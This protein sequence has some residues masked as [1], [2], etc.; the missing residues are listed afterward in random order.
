MGRDNL[1]AMD[2]DPVA[3]AV[4]RVI[5]SLVTY[6]GARWLPGCLASLRA[7]TLADY[8]LRVL[9]NAS[10]DGT[11]DLLSEFAAG[12]PRTTARR[13][14]RNL[15]FSA[16]HNQ[17]IAAAS[18]PFVLFLNQDVELDPRFLERAIAVLEA[19][20]RVAAVQGLLLVLGRPGERTSTIDTTGLVMGRS[21]RIVARR[22]ANEITQQDLVPGPVWGADG[23]APVYRAAVLRAI[24]PLIDSEPSAPGRREVFDETFFM[25]KEDVDLAWRLRASGTL[26]W[27]EPS[28][29]AWHARDS[30]AS[31]GTSLLGA[32]RRNRNM[33]EWIRAASWRNHRLMMIKN[34][35]ATDLLRDLPWI[36]TREFAS[37]AYM[38]M[39]DRV[40]LRAVAEAMRLGPAMVAKRR[41]LRRL[42]GQALTRRSTARAPRNVGLPPES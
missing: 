38:V 36:L 10:E 22:Q 35:R 32:V 24:S 3:S 21:R 16:A 42:G 1:C 13:S 41:A 14:E 15:G 34:E 9:D 4:P 12:E 26:T 29:V 40:R 18:S 8:A 30:G 11:W 27:Y 17:N 39:F 31:A 2:E 7:Q 25:Y 28:A 37:L 19:R 6:N 20:P 5:V 23:P 33:P